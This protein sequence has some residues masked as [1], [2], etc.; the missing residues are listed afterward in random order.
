MSGEANVSPDLKPPARPLPV[1]IARGF[2][3]IVIGTF[4]VAAEL[5]RPLYRPLYEALDRLALMRRFEA[6]IARLP[7]YL[8]LLLLAVPFL[9]VE[10]LKILAVLW[11]AE[12][13]VWPGLALMA[14]AYLGSF[15]LVER[16]YHAGRAKL[17]EIGWF[18]AVMGFIIRIREAVLSRVRSL[19]VVQSALRAVRRV[20]T[21]LSWLFRP[22]SGA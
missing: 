10:P 18:A 20:R 8:V 19:A 6:A 9:G 17:F 7:S 2:A 15:V 21:R 14:G 12:G 22:R 16:I 13:R 3:D 5:V 1:R 11:L 4:V